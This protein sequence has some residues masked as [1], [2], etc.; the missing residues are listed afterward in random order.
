[1]AYGPKFRV[2]GISPDGHT[3]RADIEQEGYSGSV[4]T[5][6]P[7]PDG[8]Q[9]RW[10][11]QS[12]QDLNEPWM[13]GTGSIRVKEE[14]PSPLAEI[15]DG[16]QFEYRVSLYQD[17]DLYFRGFAQTD[18]YEDSLW[19]FLSDPRIRFADGLGKLRDIAFQEAGSEEDVREALIRALDLLPNDLKSEVN[20]RWFP[21]GIPGSHPIE[22]LYVPDEAWHEDD[23]DTAPNPTPKRKS[24]RAVLRA[25]LRRF[26]MRL[27]QS[28][29][30][31]RMRQ[32]LSLLDD[33]L[34]VATYNQNGVRMTSGTK[35]GRERDL[36]TYNADEESR[37]FQ[38]EFGASSVQYN[39][40][41]P[42]KQILPNASFEEPFTEWTTEGDAQRVDIDTVSARTK[43]SDDKKA[44]KMTTADAK[45][46][47]TDVVEIP[48]DPRIA[49]TLTWSDIRNRDFGTTRGKVAVHSS[50]HGL[51][52]DFTTI[53]NAALPGAET[54]L[55][56]ASTVGST[57]GSVQGT[58]L[59]PA[60]TELR[61]FTDN[62]DTS[63]RGNRFTLSEP[64]RVG[65]QS[66]TGRLAQEI[67]QQSNFNLKPELQ[68]WFWAG[69]GYQ[70]T[71]IL[72]KD[73]FTRHKVQVFM[74]TRQA[75][76]V[77]GPLMAQWRVGEASDGGFYAV[78]DVGMT[79]ERDGE[80][81]QS[82]TTTVVDETGA[83]EVQEVP[84]GIG[85]SEDTGSRIYTQSEPT[86]EGWGR[87]SSGDSSLS[88]LQATESLQMQRTSTETREFG[89]RLRSGDQ[90]ILPHHIYLDGSTRYEAIALRRNLL[91]GTAR[92]NLAEIQDDGTDGL[93]VTT[94][95]E[96]ENT[97]ASGG[98]GSSVQVLDGQGGSASAWDDI[99][100]KPD[101]L[102]A[103][104][105]GTDSYA[106][107]VPLGKADI[108]DSLSHSPGLADGIQTEIRSSANDKALAT[109]SAV[110]SYVDSNTA[111]AGELD[112]DGL[113]ASGGLLNVKP[114]DFAGTGLTGA[115]DDLGIADA[116]VGTTQLAPDAVTRDKIGDAAV[117]TTQ[118]GANAVTRSKVADGQTFPIDI[119]GNADTVDGYDG[120][121][122]AV[123][124]EDES[125]TGAWDHANPLK[126]SSG[127]T[128]VGY[129]GYFDIPVGSQDSKEY[130]L[131]S[132]TDGNGNNNRVTGRLFMGRK[133]VSSSTGFATIYFHYDQDSGDGS[134]RNLYV[135][136]IE[137]TDTEN[138]SVRPVEVTYDGTTWA[139]IEVDAGVA[140]NDRVAR[141]DHTSSYDRSV[142]QSR[143]FSEVSGV[144]EWEASGAGTL[145]DLTLPSRVK[146][147]TLEVDTF[148]PTSPL[149]W[150]FFGDEKSYEGYRE[151]PVDTA[152]TT[153]YVLISK[154]DGT[155]NSQQRV[156]G[157]LYYGRTV[158]SSVNDFANVYFYYNQNQGG[159][160]RNFY[161]DS[162]EDEEN[163][164]GVNA[165]PV[166]VT[167]NGDPWAA[168]EMKGD[169]APAFRILSP[170][171]TGNYDLSTVQAVSQSSVSGVMHWA[172]SSKGSIAERYIS[173]TLFSEG[174]VSAGDV[175]PD[176]G[177]A[178]DIGA[179]DNKWL[180]LHAAE[181]RVSTLTAAEERVTTG[182]RFVVGRS[183][184][185]TRS[186]AAGDTT[187]YV[188][189]NNLNS[190][191]ILHLEA[192]GTVEFMEVTSTYTDE[193]DDY[194]YSV[195]RDLDGTGANA[196][197]SGDGVFNTGQSGE[198][199]IDLYAVNRLVEGATST[200]A[201]PT[202]EFAERTGSGYNDIAARAVVG[203]LENSFGYT[204]EIYGLAAGDPDGEQITATKDGVAVDGTLTAEA[205]GVAKQWTVGDS[206]YMW[207][208]SESVSGDDEI[209][210]SSDGAGDGV[211]DF[212]RLYQTPSSA[213]SWGLQGYDDGSEVFHLGEKYGS[214]AHRIAG[215]TME[216]S[217]LSAQDDAGG[218]VAVGSAIA[219][220]DS[221]D[222][223]T[224][225]L[226]GGVPTLKLRKSSE[227]YYFAQAADPLFEMKWEG[228][229]IF[230]V[231]SEGVFLDEMELR[232]LVATD[233]IQ[234]GGDAVQN[235]IDIDGSSAEPQVLFYDD[236]DVVSVMST[237]HAPSGYTPTQTDHVDITTS[238]ET[239]LSVSMSGSQG[240]VIYE[241]VV[242]DNVQSPAPVFLRFEDQNGN[243]LYTEEE[244]FQPSPYAT[245]EGTFALPDGVTTVTII[246]YT[247]GGPASGH[248][249]EPSDPTGPSSSQVWGYKPVTVIDRRG[250][251]VK[252]GQG[253]E[254][255]I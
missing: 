107:T 28:A 222:S 168:V 166:E 81:I 174:L 150:S 153:E 106:D 66:V 41:T 198:G 19:R 124:A 10:D 23:T 128:G 145:A 245:T 246:V 179:P 60:G 44:V 16:G 125:I 154:L 250:V 112:G 180:S 234:V 185:L 182:G 71:Q 164:G 239:S 207:D 80:A 131:I 96:G 175:D 189:H 162:I 243:S 146:I 17:S 187:I 65:D 91:Q 163:A 64:L 215:L 249:I 79:F 2:E 26:G 37:S 98:G 53:E 113:K 196:W 172:D 202:I 176:E 34:E 118:I 227:S 206:I 169:W 156:M 39:F 75:N 114:S 5:F 46:K 58:P 219:P 251:T 134:R 228:D 252:K 27:M 170:E 224:F 8:L 120:S 151:I 232:S 216:S 50:S 143:G 230:N 130:V 201:G 38:G 238:K 87:D 62:P 184:E 18:L 126:W 15:F 119:F 67:K 7:A 11:T 95:F 225:G 159:G 142:L 12:R 157:R 193:G 233:T 135:E 194:S 104:T 173:G 78:N 155:D 152:S 211:S 123:L 200:I 40:K 149:E 147:G 99:T 13:I 4:T 92:L 100:G 84:V 70:F 20:M 68:Y 223:A 76:P 240:Q 140:I 213:D 210:V 56:L 255:S 247:Q 109:E 122:L 188:K 148:K 51:A 36:T 24:G 181:L 141:L 229:K 31:W 178:R 55:S 208:S 69:Q 218:S 21:N 244:T 117:G 90:D 144:T 61:I 129:A 3:Y 77:H 220:K 57:T 94:S 212:V 235:R 93:S 183:T 132:R 42:L 209:R 190:G 33:S 29:G 165:R 205:G 127:V 25:L 121:E 108:A 85:P 237:E 191:D 45:V 105:G 115:N 236:G 97:V 195:T 54:T 226:W 35:T 14:D 242:R 111:A 177:Y 167:Y 138:V 88:E 231:G 6:T 49:M 137:N 161:V 89:I 171:H 254:E 221:D 83:R 22:Q 9:L 63:P 204:S 52:Q 74:V 103:R 248:Y 158:N 72:N 82:F 253:I 110:Q 43:T 192:R 186:L 160:S 217:V 116:G 48:K 47:I 86:P 136:A 197:S 241:I 133:S 203:N 214:A 1:M 139:A 101:D 59:M 32:R 73:Y 199:F 102:F 30:K